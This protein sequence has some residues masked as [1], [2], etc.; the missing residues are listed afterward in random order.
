MITLRRL[1][2]LAMRNRR[3]VR[4]LPGE[5]AARPL[6]VSPDA[7]LRWLRRDPW[8]DESALVFAVE[9]LARPGDVV[10]DLGANV[11]AFGLC[12]AARTRAPVLMVEADAFLADLLRDSAR[13]NP[14]LPIEVLCCAVGESEGVARFAIAGR[15]RS[16]N[17]LVEGKISTQ[18]GESREVRLVP[19]LSADRLLDSFPAPTV[20]KV[21][22]EGGEGMFMKGARRLLGDI[23]PALYIEVHRDN[24]PSVFRALADQ[25]Y[26]IRQYH[27]GSWI[28][29]SDDPPSEDFFSVPVEKAA[30]IF[31]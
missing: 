16:T 14:D 22:L 2:E 29:V 6:V 8:R 21:D 3:L 12:A 15:G 1:A 30:E 7:S 27:A 5:F 26:E 28:A 4:H 11:G 25:D 9:R 24:R 10:W 18:H 19:T 20:V 13:R 31:V 17:G 23:R